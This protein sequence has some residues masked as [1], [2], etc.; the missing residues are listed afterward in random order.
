VKEV[1]AGEGARSQRFVV[2]VN[3]EAKVRDAIVRQNLVAYL[4]RRIEGSDQWPKQHRDE[5]PASSG[6][7]RVLPGSSGGRR[8]TS[9]ASTRG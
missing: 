7:H 9:F 8:R 2:R 3:P 4:E 5:E 1:C 6:R